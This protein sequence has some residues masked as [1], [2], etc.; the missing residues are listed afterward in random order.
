MEKALLGNSLNLSLLMRQECKTTLVEI[1]NT[2]SVADFLRFLLVVFQTDYICQ[3]TNAKEMIERAKSMPL[4][5]KSIYASTMDQINC[6]SRNQAK[7]A[8]RIL[9]W[10]TFACRS[11]TPQELVEALAV[12]DNTSGLD[13][14]NKSSPTTLARIC[15]GL[16]IV[17]EENNIVQLAHQTI[18]DFLWDLHAKNGLNIQNEICS[19]CL[20]YLSFDV[21]RAGPS[22]TTEEYYRQNGQ[23]VFQN[24]ACWHL[25][26][27]F[28]WAAPNEALLERMYELITCK[29]LVESYL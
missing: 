29:P 19:I 23:Y 28:S 14:L 17:D 20:T 7:L 18:Q 25:E 13:P 27:H 10:L 26:D 9:I 22:S 16:V 4:D 21:F 2:D 12:E 5:A 1:Y 6:Q 24:Y 11:L 3:Q 8:N 15:R